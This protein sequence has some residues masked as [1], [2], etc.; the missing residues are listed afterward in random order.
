MSMLQTYSSQSDGY[1]ENG[2]PNLGLG[3]YLKIAKRRAL[4]F[5]GA[6]SLVLLLGAFVTAIQRPLYEASGRVLVESQEIPADLVQPTVTESANER[7]QV[8]Q[9][10]I[11]TRDNL[12]G[13]VKKYGMFARERQWMSD[14]QILDLMRKRT[15]FALVDLNSSPGRPGASTIAFTVSFEYETREATLQVTNSLLTLILN[16]DARSRANRATQTTEF[17]AHESQRLQAELASIDAQI[18]EARA[19]QQ[20][21]PAASMDPVKLQVAELTKLKEDLAQQGAIY[22]DA[23]PAIIALKKK[24][25]AMEKLV[26]QAP[27]QRATQANSA[28]FELERERVDT[29]TA[30]Q[31]NSKKLETARLGQKLEQ[32]Q[33]AQRLQVIEQPVLPEKPVKPNR[34][35]L[36]ALSFALAI[37]AGFGAIFAAESLDGSIRHGHQLA[38]VASG[39]L[40]VSIPH[41][42]TRAE[43]SRRKSRGLLLA[44][45]VGVGLLAGVVGLL[46][47]GP[48]IDLSWIHQFWIDRLTSL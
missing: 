40:I 38:A 4:Y 16:E 6:F 17:L 37:A 30:L 34:P 23:Y 9:Q 15:Q 33:Q 12:L 20:S 8:I 29:E 47:F 42:S 19:R 21:E 27:P 43:M 32:D 28:L 18:A 35:K 25:A 10:R 36:L 14:T 11:M 45:S 2:G 41:I 24:I 46:F 48:A 26:A 39:R 1:E 3:H 13:L 5:A 7:I 44:G 22:S 31:L